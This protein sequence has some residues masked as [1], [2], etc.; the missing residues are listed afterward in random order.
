LEAIGR[1]QLSI[2]GSKTALAWREKEKYDG[3]GKKKRKGDVADGMIGES[4]TA[5]K[6]WDGAGEVAYPP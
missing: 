6:E 4:F 1:T 5:R 3:L 2:E